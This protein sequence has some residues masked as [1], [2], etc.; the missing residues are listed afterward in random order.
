VYFDG[1]HVEHSAAVG[2]ATET[3]MGTHS[4]VK[5]KSPRCCHAAEVVGILQTVFD[6]TVDWR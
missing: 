6:F 4:T 2:S 1:V 5:A 3:Q